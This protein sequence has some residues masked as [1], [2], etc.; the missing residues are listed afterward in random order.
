[1]PPPLLMSPVF[2]HPVADGR[3]KKNAKESESQHRKNTE[4]AGQEH[5]EPHVR[6]PQRVSCCA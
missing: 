3:P 4:E 5:G 1:M 6:L 2:S